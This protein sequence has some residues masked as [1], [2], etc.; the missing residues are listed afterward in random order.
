MLGDAF[1]EL[2]I[3]IRW[4][5]GN[6]TSVDLILDPHGFDV[7]VQ[8][9]RLSLVTED[10]ARRLLRRPLPNEV[11]LLVVADRVTEDARALLTSSGA[12]Y[13][14]LRGRL[15]LRSDRLLIGLDLAGASHGSQRADPFSGRVGLEVGVA[16]LMTPNR[17]VTVRGLAR[18]L[19]RSPSTV[20]A[21]LGALRR[22]NLIDDR[23]ALTGTEL[24]W[25]LA[26]R[27]PSGR[28][29][30]AN[31]PAA[32]RN[33]TVP[34]R[35]GLDDLSAPGWA[36]TDTAAAAAYGAGVAVR[37]D[38]SLD[39]FVPDAAT[40]RRATRL[41]GEAVASRHARASVRVGPVPAAV[42]PR[43]DSDTNP[44]EWPLSHPVLV[45]LDLA[46]DV[47]RGRAVLEEWTPDSRWHRVW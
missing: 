22:N 20:S 45:A 42:S 35:L 18:D 3:P 14:D 33:D 4:Q 9:K 15:A 28:I 43:F 2:G 8:L 17:P 16:V 13:L 5:D 23:N 44:F 38:Q 26:D 1:A 10:I 19:K 12:G 37:S 27:W 30:L 46:Q 11:V 32:G 29:H 47:G 39:F 21:V 40:A 41:L 24:F 7:H 6:D 31:L 34:L 36:L 25:R